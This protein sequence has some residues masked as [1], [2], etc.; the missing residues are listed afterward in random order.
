MR[1]ATLIVMKAWAIYTPTMSLLASLGLVLVTGFGAKAVVSG[2]RARRA[3][4]IQVTS[5]QELH[6]TKTSVVSSP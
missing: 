5:L 2:M 1:E 6:E 4:G 3:S